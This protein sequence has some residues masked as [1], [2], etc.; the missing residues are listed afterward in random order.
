MNCPVCGT[1][2]EFNKKL[3]RVVCS[4]CAFFKLPYQN[5]W[6]RHSSNVKNLAE[7]IK[8]RFPI[9]SLKM[10]LGA[11][12]NK[13]VDI[14]PDK[15][16]EPDIEVWWKVHILSIEVTGSAKRNVPPSDIWI[17]AKKLHV[18]QESIVSHK[19]YLFYTKFN[20]NSFTI[21]VSLVE[22]YRSNITILDKYGSDERYIIIPHQEAKSR[23]DLF[24]TIN[25]RL[26]N[27]V[28]NILTKPDLTPK[29]LPGM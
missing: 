22:K 19:E 23:E 15:K 11:E 8:S 4:K 13:W 14:P 20:N 10:G 1:P 5:E 3:Q 25:D 28:G 26:N 24:A 12:S 16:N 29:R 6:Q 2:L 7:E 21:P 18:A 17:L 27:L 9:V